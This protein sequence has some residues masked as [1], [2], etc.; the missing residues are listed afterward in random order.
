MIKK[1]KKKSCKK[2]MELSETYDA[3]PFEDFDPIEKLCRKYDASMF[4][5]A[6]HSKKRPNNLVIGEQ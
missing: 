6:S 5:F 1:E 4:V 2:P 3:S